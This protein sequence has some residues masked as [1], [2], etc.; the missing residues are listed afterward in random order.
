MLSNIVLMDYN[1]L[2]DKKQLTRHII[3][4]LC[5]DLQNCPISPFYN[6]MELMMELWT[7]YHVNKR[8]LGMNGS[9]G[10]FFI[11]NGSN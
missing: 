5:L 6:H 10:S 8:F 7:Q 9:N 4:V 2:L 11:S 3:S 1:I